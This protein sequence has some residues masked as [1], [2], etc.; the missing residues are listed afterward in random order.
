MGRIETS[1]KVYN[2]VNHRRQWDYENRFALTQQMRSILDEQA[3]WVEPIDRAFYHLDKYQ[4]DPSRSPD[5]I[6]NIEDIR[7][8]LNGIRDEIM[9]L[10]ARI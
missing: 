9:R 4:P 5:L 6:K 7:R 1:D 8:D 3:V 10:R 2:Q